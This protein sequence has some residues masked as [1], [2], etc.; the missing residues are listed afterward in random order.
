V[1]AAFH[2]ALVVVLAGIVLG[3]WPAVLPHAIA[4]RL[5]HNSEGFLLALLLTPRIQFARPRL[6]GT[7]RQWPVTGAAAALCAA[8]GAFLLVTQL[9][10]VL[11]T[12][13]EAFLG[14]AL[15][16]PY[17]QLRRPLP[18]WAPV[19]L[20]AVAVAVMV[21]GE[22]THPVT[23]LAEVLGVLVLAPIGLD[24]VDRAI[25]DGSARPSPRLR[26]GWYAFLVAAPVLFSVL[27]YRVGVGGG[28]LRYAVRITEA[29]VCLL[30]VE[31][32]FAVTPPRRRP[33]P[34]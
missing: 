5:G 30:L 8:T 29:F 2:G 9:P 21:L 10:P 1:G 17:V 3:V 24:L 31:L 14:A 15:L 6:A 12:L 4:A 13:N 16:I 33:P 11:R 25:L 26:C 34:D 23:D 27:E 7:A 20:P 32:Y 18:R 19:L 22:R 28:A